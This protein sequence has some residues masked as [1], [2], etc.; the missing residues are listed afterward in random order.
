MNTSSKLNTDNTYEKNKGY[1]REQSP[2]NII[3]EIN[4]D[5]NYTKNKSNS[6]SNSLT[7]YS[8]DWAKK[9]LFNNYKL[10]LLENKNNRLKMV[11]AS[12]KYINI[13]NLILRPSIE[14]H[15][16]SNKSSQNLKNLDLLKKQG[17]FNSKVNITITIITIIF[18]I[19]TYIILEFFNRTY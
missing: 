10:V 16:T 2:N 4:E 13:L 6:L 11:K 17:T 19:N 1:S 9:I 12:T 7:P 5:K 18:Y 15:H 3:N 8:I 14:T